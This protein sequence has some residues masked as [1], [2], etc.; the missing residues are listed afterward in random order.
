MA[1]T[2]GLRF[3]IHRRMDNIKPECTTSNRGTYTLA[4]DA[5]ADIQ[6]RRLL[7]SHRVET[8]FDPGFEL[9]VLEGVN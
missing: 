3:R 5:R 1:A 6:S 2:L 9:D 7:H 8:T 4:E